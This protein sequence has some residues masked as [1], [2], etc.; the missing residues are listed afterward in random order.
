MSGCKVATEKLE[1]LFLCDL[2]FFFYVKNNQHTPTLLK[3][4]WEGN[5]TDFLPFRVLS[6]ELFNQTCLDTGVLGFLNFIF[7]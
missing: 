5:V 6:V 3:N 2:N 1:T 4:Y 7:N